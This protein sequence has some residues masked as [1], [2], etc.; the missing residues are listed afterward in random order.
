MHN[1]KESKRDLNLNPEDI[2]K[3]KR[4][5]NKAFVAYG[6]S[7]YDPE[8]AQ[9]AVFEGLREEHPKFKDKKDDELINQMRIMGANLFIILGIEQPKTAKKY[10]Q[11]IERLTNEAL[12]QQE[13]P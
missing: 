7:N 5:I 4:I 9:K 10:K 3:A 6:T 1:K 13:T 12:E 11:T 2:A 8:S